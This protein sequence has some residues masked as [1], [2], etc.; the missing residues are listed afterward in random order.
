MAKVCIATLVLLWSTLGWAQNIPSVRQWVSIFDEVHQ[1]PLF[2]DLKVTY[3]KTPAESVG[4][5]PVGVV[6]REGVDCV[7]VISEGDNAKMEQ[8]LA[9]IPSQEATQAFLMT[10]AAHE[11]GHCF[12]IRHR[13]LSVELWERVLATAPGTAE[14]QA[15]EKRISLEEGYADAY[16]FAYLRDAHAPMYTAMFKAMHRLR[17]EPAFATPF[18]QVEPLY[19][20]LGSRGLDASLPLQLQVEA[21]MKAAK[22]D[23]GTASA[24]KE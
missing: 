3:A 7:V 5:S 22:F 14:R 21:I 11:F 8:I 16:A 19:V 2:K 18:Y 9:L 10:M 12:R 6:P 24:A 4:F 17:H 20:Q 23:G 13:H 1:H 15:M